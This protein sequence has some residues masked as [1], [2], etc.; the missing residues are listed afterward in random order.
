MP[1]LPEVE[2]VRRYLDTCLSGGSIARVRLARKDLRFPF[3]VSFTERLTG[4]R[5]LKVSRRAKY[6]LIACEKDARKIVWLVHLGMSGKL[7]WLPNEKG[8]EQPREQGLGV[9]HRHVCVDLRECKDGCGVL[10][11]DDARRFG[12]MDLCNG[13]AMANDCLRLQKLGIEPLSNLFSGSWLWHSVVCTINNRSRGYG[14]T[15]K[16]ILMDQGY[17]AGLGNIYVTEGLWH[18]R[19]HPMR[20]IKDITLD[21]CERISRGIRKVLRMAIDAGGSSLKDYRKGDG[22]LGYFQLNLRAYGRTNEACLRK[23]CDGKINKATIGGRASYFCSN[24]AR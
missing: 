10:C 2:T 21:D 1:E 7:L 17:V 11:Y 8:D 22:S 9:D 13:D 5:I 14:R 24:V 23:D 6:L 3:P 20:V 16:D 19:V 12:F 18:A 15:I 4:A